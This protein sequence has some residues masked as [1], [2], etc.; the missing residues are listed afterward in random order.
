VTIPKIAPYD[1]PV[2]SDLPAAVT[3][4]VPDA[5]RAVLVVH[6]MQ[7]YFV[8]FF[9]RTRPPMAPLIDNIRALLTVARA[10]AVPVVY[11][12]QP[13]G[14]ARA[15]RGLLQD[16][17]GPGMSADRTQREII[18]E[19]VPREDEP[20]V[21]RWR[22]SAFARTDLEDRIRAGGRDQ[23]ILCGIYAHVGCLTTATDAFGRDIE[24]FLVADAVADFTRDDHL[25]A[26]RYAARNCARIPTT[27]ELCESL[28]TPAARA[29][30]S[31]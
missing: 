5:A 28:H 23:L 6:D 27:A 14:M 26:L 29:P 22:Y 10:V 4:W 2:P 15:D 25:M 19:L 16:V 31:G 1:L 30:S 21:T 20:F 13:G 3:T 24:T 8:D 9:D 18:A 7:R 12:G 11:T 17:W